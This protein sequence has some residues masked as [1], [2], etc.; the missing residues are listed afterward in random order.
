[1][2]ITLDTGHKPRIIFPMIKVKI[3]RNDPCSCGSGKKFKKCCLGKPYEP[4]PELL[5]DFELGQKR[6]QEAEEEDRKAGRLPPNQIQN[7]SPLAVF[8][9]NLAFPMGPTMPLKIR[10][11]KTP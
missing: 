2:Q 11:T 6:I 5:A 4:S 1:M 7:F 3:G 9:G 10:H 8:G